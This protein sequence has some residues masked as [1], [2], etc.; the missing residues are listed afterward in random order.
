M[1]HLAGFDLTTL[2][3]RRAPF[4]PHTRTPLLVFN[5]T[6]VQPIF[7]VVNCADLVLSVF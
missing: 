7:A 6:F 3:M 1:C 4:Q 2:A 5:K